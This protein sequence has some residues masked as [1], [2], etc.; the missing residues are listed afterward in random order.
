MGDFCNFVVVMR[1]I[2]DISA[3]VRHFGVYLTVEKGLAHNTAMAYADD[4]AKLV[5]YLQTE[6]VEVE[7]VTRSVLDNFLCTLRDVGIGP[8]SQARTGFGQRYV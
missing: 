8:R 6:G 4:V 1:K 5:A 2:S 3:T 7:D